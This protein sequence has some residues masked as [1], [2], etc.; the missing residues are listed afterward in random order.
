MKIKSIESIL[1]DIPTKRVHKLSFGSVTVQNY[2]IVRIRSEDGFEGIGEASTIGGPSWA[3]ESTETI[4]LIIDTYLAPHLIGIDPRNIRAIGGLMDRLA[5]GNSFAKA[6]IEMALVDL[7]ARRLGVPA[8]QLYG[9]KLRDHIE[10]ASTLASGDTAQDIEEGE[11]KLRLSQHRI[12]KLKIGYGEPN[13]DVAHV[14]SI[15]A[16]FAGR[17]RVHVDV[18]QA[19]DEVTA[20]QCISQLQAAGVA[21][22]EQPVARDQVDAMARLTARFDTLIMAD[23]SLASLADAHRL[24]QQHA[25]DVFALKLTKAGGPFATLKVAALAEAAGIPCYGGCMLETSVGTA[26]Y[27]HTFVAVAGLTQACELFGPMLLKDDLVTK[28]L[29]FGDFAIHLH[30]GVGYGVE[31]DPEKI[32]FYR[33]DKSP[34]VSLSLAH[35]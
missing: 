8:F 31:I 4:K 30:D 19:W 24:V 18:N 33:R 2:V 6:A 14:S 12:F 26:A 29:E 23:E 20:V 10:L 7:V 27:L 35:K 13:R 15:A 22:I 5:K 11:E 25:A 16:H 1:V 21:L 32:A 17:A 28:P 34:R 9:G 3:Q